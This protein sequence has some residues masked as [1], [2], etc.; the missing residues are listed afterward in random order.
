MPAELQAQAVRH[1]V[2]IDKQAALAPVRSQ[3]IRDV[4]ATLL[5]LSFASL[6]ASTGGRLLIRRWHLV[7]GRGGC[8][9][10]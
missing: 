2:D 3:A 7:A 9:H 6:A 5:A 1:H 4:I 8:S 10:G